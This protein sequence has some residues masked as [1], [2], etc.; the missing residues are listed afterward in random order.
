[1]TYARLVQPRGIHPA[2][3]NKKVACPRCG[4]ICDYE[5]SDHCNL[6][7]LQWYAS[8]LCLHCNYAL[9]EDGDGALPAEMRQLV[10]AQDGYWRA[11]IGGP[12]VGTLGFRRVLRTLLGLSLRE[13]LAK[14]KEFPGI[15]AVGTRAETTCLARQLIEGLKAYPEVPIEVSI[16]RV[17]L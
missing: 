13:V 1:M 14:A 10:L 4:E 8:W 3:A 12:G 7:R 16:D 9:E 6:E 2:M 5:F 17:E 11:T 15:L